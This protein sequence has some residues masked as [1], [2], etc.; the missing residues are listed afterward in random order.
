MKERKDEEP[1][2]S[3]LQQ[4]EAFTEV[5]GQVRRLNQTCAVQT[6]PKV[7]SDS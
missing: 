2:F 5:Q 1:P 3:Y 4:Q 6:S 7:D